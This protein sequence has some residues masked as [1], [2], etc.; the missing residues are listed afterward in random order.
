[1]IGP[2]AGIAQRLHSR[3]SPSI[4]GFESWLRRDSF[5]LLLSLWTV[6]QIERILILQ[7]TKLT[8]QQGI[9]QM[10]LVA[11]SRAKYYEKGDGTLSQQSVCYR[12]SKCC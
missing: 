6:F 2:G 9:S 3:F 7:L 5:S 10:Q 12:A 11:M 1:M 4:P 8:K